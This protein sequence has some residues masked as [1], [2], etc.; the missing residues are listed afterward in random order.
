MTKQLEPLPTITKRQGDVLLVIA[1]H[2]LVWRLAPSLDE[3]RAG[4][5]VAP[6]TNL[7]NYLEPLVKQG[8]LSR[9][10]QYSRRGYR[11]TELA[12]T[13]LPALLREREKEFPEIK[14]F[15]QRIEQGK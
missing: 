14:K 15:V 8:Y 1:N 13:L 11:T 12:E 3:I 10:P 5:G 7:N 4:L 2:I 6:T 9:G